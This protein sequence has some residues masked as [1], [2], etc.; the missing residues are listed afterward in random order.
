METGLQSLFL[1]E[2]EDLLALGD[3]KATDDWSNPCRFPGQ[4]AVWWVPE[5]AT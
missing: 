4:V 1:K 3:G 5:L 2:I